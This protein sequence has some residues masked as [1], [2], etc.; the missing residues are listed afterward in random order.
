MID[1]SLKPNTYTLCLASESECPLA[2]SCLRSLV[3]RQEQQ[4]L[5]EKR[6]LTIV[7]HLS[8]SLCYATEQCVAY[9]SSAK[10]RFAK[11]MTH[12]FD[13]VPHSEYT[14]IHNAVKACFSNRTF[15]FQSKTGARLIPTDTQ[16]KIREVFLQHSLSE[17]LYDGYVDQYVWKDY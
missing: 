1:T 16:A 4:A 12:M 10:S 9:N 2:A 8:E 7:N 11:G 17:P 5:A 15:F 13:N 14:V 6:K 3:Y